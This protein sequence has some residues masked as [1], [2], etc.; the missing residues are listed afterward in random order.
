MDL[1]R[2]FRFLWAVEASWDRASRVEARDFSRWLQIAGQPRRPHWRRPS[3]AGRWAAG[4]KP[5]A[6][7]VRAHSETVLRTF[8]DFHR[9][10][11]TGR[12]STRS[13]WTAHVVDGERMPIATRWTHPAM[14]APGSTGR[15]CPSECPAASPMRSSMRSS[16][17]FHRTGTEPWSPSTSPPAL[18]PVNCSA[19]GRRAWIRGVS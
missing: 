18:G 4:G 13:R 1:L 14:N 16:P 3:E 10:I 9:D 8:Y 19:H 12:S 15:E 7:S 17:G 11:G 5:Y 2:W 6:P